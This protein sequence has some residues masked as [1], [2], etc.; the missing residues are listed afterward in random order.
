MSA[1]CR[2][3]LLKRNMARP[4]Q[5]K[6]SHLGDATKVAREC[7]RIIQ[8]L[9]TPTQCWRRSKH[10]Y[11][12]HV[13]GEKYWQAVTCQQSVIQIWLFSCHNVIRCWAVNIQVG[14]LHAITIGSHCNKAGSLRLL[15]RVKSWAESS[16]NL[17]VRL[18]HLSH[19]FT[20]DCWTAFQL[21]LTTDRW[22]LTPSEPLQRKFHAWETHCAT[23]QCA[24]ITQPLAVFPAFTEPSCKDYRSSLGAAGS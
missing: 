22:P 24:M 21:S 20:C 12:D 15:S 1:E 14:C 3:I 9:Y 2:W 18:V 11:E 7:V 6:L 16:N 8:S 13:N 5:C 4:Q 19:C 17:S 10:C 23:C